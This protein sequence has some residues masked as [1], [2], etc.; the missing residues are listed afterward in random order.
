MLE[1]QRSHKKTCMKM[2]LKKSRDH[3]YQ[4]KWVE[5]LDTLILWEEVWGS[6]HN[7]LSSNTPLHQNTSKGDIM[8]NIVQIHSHRELKVKRKIRFIKNS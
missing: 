7:F 3:I 4:T 6:V 8:G 2:S 1:W 5:K